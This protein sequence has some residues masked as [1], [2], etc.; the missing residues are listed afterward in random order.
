MFNVQVNG[1]ISSKENNK[2]NS[3]SAV[4]V[5]VAVHLSI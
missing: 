4:S 1:N 5:A 2:R 3:S